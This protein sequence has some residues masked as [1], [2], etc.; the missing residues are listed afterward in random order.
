[1]ENI[2]AVVIILIGLIFCSCLLT[3]ALDEPIAK[4]YEYCYNCKYGFCMENPKSRHCMKWQ[5][6][7]HDKRRDN[8]NNNDDI[9]S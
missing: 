9:R 8:F 4:E 7:V 2:I 1:M 5:E 3:I 6:E